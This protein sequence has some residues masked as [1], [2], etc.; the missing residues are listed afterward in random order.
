MSGLKRFG[1]LFDGNSKWFPVFN[2]WGVIVAAGVA[3]FVVSV[4]SFK[5]CFDSLVVI[6]CKASVAV[7]GYKKEI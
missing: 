5:F 6:E 7:W 3:A 4:V 2:E 1:L